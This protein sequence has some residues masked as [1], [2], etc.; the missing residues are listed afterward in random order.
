M[1]QANFTKLHTYENYNKFIGSNNV[2]KLYETEPW[3]IGVDKIPLVHLNSESRNT[4][5]VGLKTSLE[6]FGIPL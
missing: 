2:M 1:Y 3:R 6:I 4:T 5:F